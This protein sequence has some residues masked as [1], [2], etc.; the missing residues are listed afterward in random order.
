MRW[1]G[2]WLVTAMAVASVA[3]AQDDTESLA[4][5][6]V[7]NPF[8]IRQGSAQIVF[9][10]GAYEIAS[11]PQ[12]EGV[13][14][15]YSLGLGATAELVH[16]PHVAMDLEFHSLHREFDTPVAAPF[17]GTI[18]NDTNIDTSAL[19]FGGRLFYPAHGPVRVYASGGFGYFRTTMSVNGSVLG[20][21]GSYE[22]S[23]SAVDLYY[24]AGLRFYADTWSLGVDYRRF[25]LESSFNDFGIRN[26]D[27]GG[28]S[29]LIGIGWRFY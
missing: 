16:S 20:I 25:D 22:E 6:P 3:M 1:R 26:A 5:E 18:D 9:Y 2:V 14:N 19:L 21:P 8:S 4:A 23:D 13:G 24:G 27:I 11:E 29:Y 28:E 15:S 17:L 7:S 10:A 12:F